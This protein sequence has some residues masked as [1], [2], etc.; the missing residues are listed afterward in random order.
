MRIL[1]FLLSLMAA[2][3][4][5]AA[6]S[7]IPSVLKDLC[8]NF[9]PDVQA[10]QLREIFSE[11][12]FTGEVPQQVV[13]SLS[14]RADRLGRCES[15]RQLEWNPQKQVGHFEFHSEHKQVGVAYLAS[16]S[17]G[18]LSSF[19]FVLEFPAD[20]S[21]MP[22]VRHVRAAD[23]VG[24]ETRLYLHPDGKGL[25]RPVLFQRTPYTRVLDLD[26][27]SYSA[28]A[29]WAWTQGYHYV[30]Q[31]VRGTGRSGGEFE[32]FSPINVE[33][34]KITLDWL[35][36]QSFSNGNV[37]IIGTSYDGFAALAAGVTNHPTLKVV[38]AGGAPTNARTDG[39]SSNGIV[40]LVLLDYL[41]YIQTQEGL[42]FS[43]DFQE[44]ARMQLLSEPDPS[45]YDN[46]LFGTNVREWDRLAPY[47]NTPEHPFWKTRSIFHLL[48]Q[49][50]V[51]TYHIA[52]MAVD[53]DLPDT[54]RN[55]RK[56]Q[57]HS[58]RPANHHLY[59]GYWNHESSTPVGRDLDYLAPELKER[60]PALLK[61]YL[62]GEAL[63]FEDS[64]ILLVSHNQPGLKAHA[65]LPFSNFPRQKLFATEV[66]QEGVKLSA[67]PASPMVRMASYFYQP[68]VF[69][70]FASGQHLNL[71]WEVDR[72]LAIFGELKYS[73]VV[74]TDAPRMDLAVVI[75]KTNLKG[76]SV[77]VSN[78][79][80][81]G[82]FLFA[83]GRR[84]LQLT[85]D[86]PVFH[87]VERGE[88]LRFTVTSNL[89][90]QFSRVLPLGSI[91]SEHEIKLRF[92]SETP[93]VSIPV[94][95]NLN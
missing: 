39:F 41:R 88:I 72:S 76:E 28:T 77:F 19:A 8:A 48:P 75:S 6:E 47:I 33:D 65:R 7:T 14:A 24:L 26:A 83:D 60:I 64:Q 90:P 92:N 50:T 68:Q 58:R 40:Q 57:A 29:Q 59:L 52:G 66:G 31:S 46:V 74:E 37:G 81:G 85:S 11:S 95:A 79:L 51:P 36:Q 78:C 18:K 15:V 53:G 73:L 84:E 69:N 56:V 89:F 22:Q 86:C 2:L 82:R 3:T 44:K 35:D 91:F 25:P 55:F 12:Y 21:P 38:L 30:V 71:S 20:R 13:S 94:E 43:A 61:H 63:G 45:G 42:P 87:K 16:D 23:G 93:F 10:E 17:R 4:I 62:K 54:L 1:V 32:L 67:Q 5:Q 9:R 80:V 34:A 70:D 49:I 27:V